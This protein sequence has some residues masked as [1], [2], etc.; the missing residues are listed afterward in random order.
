[1]IREDFF[2][3]PFEK[4]QLNAALKHSVVDKALEI[5]ELNKG[6][7]W[8]GKG[9]DNADLSPSYLEDPYFKTIESA[10]KYVSWK[11][12]ITPNS[13]RKAETPNLFIK[14]VFYESLVLKAGEV[15]FSIESNS[16]DGKKIISKFPEATGLTDENIEVTGELIKEGFFSRAKEQLHG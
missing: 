4:L 12:K 2:T 16:S 7:L 1:M 14:G 11:S 6:Q 10:K 13:N 8:D 5:V 9:R 3:K 15:E